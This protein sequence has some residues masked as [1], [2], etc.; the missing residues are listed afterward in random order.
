[1]PYSAEVVRLARKRLE[2]A[3]A[4]KESLYRERLQEAYAQQPSLREIDRE[5]AQVAAKALRAAL[6]K[7]APQVTEQAKQESL[8]LQAERKTIVDTCFAPGYL[9]DSPV[10]SLCGG[11][12][13]IGTRMCDCLKALCRQEQAKQITLLASERERF[14][15]FRLDYYPDTVDARYGVSPRRVM[16]RTYA[17]C[18]D[19]AGKFSGGNL[20]F[21]GGT[22]LG[23]TFLSACI[24]REVAQQ[25]YSVC[26][27]PAS[28]LFS[29][30]EKNQ[31]N[32]DEDSQEMASRLYDCDL[33]IVDDLGTELP[34]GFT[35]AA[36]YGLLNERLLSGKSM[37]ISTNLNIDELTAR[38]SPQVAS[39]L[40]GSFQRLTFV[41]EDIRVAKNRGVLV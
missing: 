16:E 38:Y 28:R 32:P 37:V 33:L 15:N 22:G 19:F 7:D 40:Q 2:S 31:F 41:G 14:E 39:R 24:A 23:K 20:L 36:L 18:K 3:K 34:G 12:G 29:K 6:T 27:E 1:M 35:T 25:G 26:Y 13:Y 4:D 9:D 11:S 10:C 5:L 30:L 17:I 21:V 8:A